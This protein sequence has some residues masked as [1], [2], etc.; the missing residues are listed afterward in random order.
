MYN[1]KKIVGYFDS[2]KKT[3]WKK[4]IYLISIKLCTN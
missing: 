3:I 4:Y 2:I 1:G